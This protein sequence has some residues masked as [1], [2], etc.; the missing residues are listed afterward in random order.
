M[1]A[2]A[3][4][5]PIVDPVRHKR[6]LQTLNERG[7]TQRGKPRSKDPARNP[8]GSRIFDMECGWPM[9]RKPYGSFRISVGC[10]SR[11]KRSCGHHQSMVPRLRSSSC[12]ASS[13]EF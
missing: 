11:A 4:F 13:N 6:L 2:A 3:R 9:Y 1:E 5:D 10:T 7:A 8:L 12:A